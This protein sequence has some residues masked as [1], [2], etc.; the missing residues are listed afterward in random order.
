MSDAIFE[1]DQAFGQMM[2]EKYPI[3]MRGYHHLALPVVRLMQR[4]ETATRIVHTIATP[5][6]NEM[7]YQMGVLEQG[8][9]TGKIIMALGLTLC[10]LTGLVVSISL[11]VQFSLLL[12]LIGLI[13]ISRRRRGTVR[14]HDVSEIKLR[15]QH[16]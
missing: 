15:H 10:L 11:Q 2:R 4:S 3:V 6:A 8:D 13:L 12:L 9:G 5:W 1:A 14:V 7:A 16:D